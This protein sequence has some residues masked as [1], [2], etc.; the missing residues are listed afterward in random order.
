MEKNIALE[1]LVEITNTNL[2]YVPST[3]TEF[4]E[5]CRLIQKKTGRSISLSSV[6]RIWGYVKY[7]GFPSV[8]TLNNLAQYNGFKDWESFIIEKPEISSRSGFLEG[9]V[10][11]GGRMKIGER[12]SL[13]WAEGKSCEI[14]CIGSSRFRVSKSENI[15]LLTGD[16]FTLHTI[17]LGQPLYITN[18]RRDNLLIP[19]YIGAKNGGLATIAIESR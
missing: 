2:G 17:C 7:E 16:T 10:I 19:A 12:L 15:K 6:K 8:T 13:C 9:S 14:E 11:Q 18:I 5:V 4:N 3:P 1:T